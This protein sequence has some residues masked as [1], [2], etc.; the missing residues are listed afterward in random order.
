[1]RFSL[2]LSSI[3]ETSSTGLGKSIVSCFL[4]SSIYYTKYIVQSIKSN[5]SSDE[6]SCVIF[7]FLYILSTGGRGGVNCVST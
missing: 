6:I 2:D 3:N 5:P 4:M 7:Y 1:M